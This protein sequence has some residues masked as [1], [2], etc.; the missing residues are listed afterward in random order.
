[1]MGGGGALTLSLS[2][3]IDSETTTIGALDGGSPMSH[4]NFKKINGNV[5]CLCHLF[6][7]M[8]HVNFKKRLCP[9][10]L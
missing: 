3:G 8:S 4:V 5:A 10:S 2:L 7:P 1:M 9:M 6:S